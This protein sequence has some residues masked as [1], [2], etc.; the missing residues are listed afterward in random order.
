MKLSNCLWKKVDIK[1]IDGKLY[2]G[3]YVVA[4]NDKY[5]NIDENEDSIGIKPSKTSKSGI[6]LFESQIKDIEIVI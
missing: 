2:K 6:E 1:C 4:Y 3:Y 5:D